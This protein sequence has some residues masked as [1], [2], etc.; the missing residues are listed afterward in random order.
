[1]QPLTVG[2]L[3]Q[4][5]FSRPYFDPEGLILAV[6]DGTPVGFVHAGFGPNEESTALATDVGTTFV[7]M[8]RGDHRH[9]ALADELL[10]H[11]ESYLRGRG[12]KVLYAGG[13]RPL[14]A[15]YLGLY[16]GSEL[17]GVLISDP[18]LA[19]ACQR[20]NYREIDRVIVLERELSRFRQPVT[21]EQRQIRRDMTCREIYGP[22]AANWWEACTVGAFE[23]LRFTLE[24]PGACDPT[25]DVWFWDIEPLS[26]GWGIP[27]AGMFDLCVSPTARRSGLATFLLSE[28]FARLRNRGVVLV[29]AQ[30]MRD[31]TPALALY[32]KLGFTKVDE[33]VIYRKE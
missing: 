10:A 18:V 19:D 13:I 12:A 33:G 16:G 9:N 22:P 17:P 14:N 7:L 32:N 23:R 8:L 2:L 31:N 15:F 27:T 21:R 26:T 11:S 4:F 28:A 20:N 3:E 6:H 30:T 25:A 29:E 24:R 5:I 1:M